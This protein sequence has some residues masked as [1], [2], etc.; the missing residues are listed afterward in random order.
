MFDIIG[1]IHGKGDAL[2]ALLRHLGYRDQRGAFRHPV[3][4]AIFL[5]DFV[6]RGAQIREALGIVRR[7]VDSGTALAVMGN[8]ELNFLAHHTPHPS[9]AGE[10]L[11]ERSKKGQVAATIEQLPPAELAVHLEWFRTLPLW[12]D[13]DGLRVVHACWDAECIAMLADR[14][15]S[16]IDDG[17][18]AA[19]CL[20]DGACHR[21]VQIT[22]KGKEAEL[23]AGRTYVD[24]RGTT[25]RE[26][27]L[28][29][30]QSPEGK[31][32]AEYALA[33][34]VIECNQPL[35][36]AVRREARPY[37][38]ADKPVFV[39]HYGLEGDRL[40]GLLATNVACVD[41]VPP[42]DGLCAYRWDGEHDLRMEN[43]VMV[44]GASRARGSA[45]ARK[46]DPCTH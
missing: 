29:W 5:G 12:L 46:D 37:P 45:G 6:D 38:A 40:P 18:L 16:R 36:E 39:G 42:G 34:E 43:F 28:R 2:K 14:V 1:D 33:S 8:H 13:L 15:P 20:E 25:R 35:E 23:P 41:W 17:F 4:R 31:T 11:R 44:P 9:A 10:C 24:K 26:M 7:M 3:R 27:R 32:Y 30:Y 19:A 22:L 21:P